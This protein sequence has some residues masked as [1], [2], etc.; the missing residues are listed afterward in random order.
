M[1][2]LR[3]INGTG[4]VADS[5]GLTCAVL[6]RLELPADLG[7]NQLETVW[8]VARQRSDND[9]NR[10]IP[11][12]Y[13][14]GRLMQTAPITTSLLRAMKTIILLSLSNIFKTFAWYAHLKDR[15][16]KPWIIVLT[17]F[18]PFAL[19][20][21]K[22]PLRIDFDAHHPWRTALRAEL[23]FAQFRSWRNCLWAGLCLVG[24]ACFMFR[25]PASG[26]A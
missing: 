19:F 1:A 5:M 14:V 16:D 13:R 8:R 11:D 9:H 15:R 25:A 4:V 7:H 12:E 6:L 2:L 21:M 24:A 17:V 10:C 18:A 20:Y 22:E 3:I 23:K 26:G